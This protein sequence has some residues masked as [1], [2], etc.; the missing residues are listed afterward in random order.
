MTDPYPINSAQ[1]LVLAKEYT[2]STASDL[3]GLTPISTAGAITA[4]QQAAGVYLHNTGASGATE[5][6]LAT[7][8]VGDNIYVAVRANQALT[9]DL[10]VG[11]IIDGLATT[12]QSYTA[13]A[14]GESLW[15][16]CFVAGAFTRMAI[17]GSWTAS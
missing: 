12:G 8:S 7:P 17:N 13:D 6:D 2:D 5:F 4:A 3:R 9:L 14:I 11:T 15:L 10:P 16:H 1:T